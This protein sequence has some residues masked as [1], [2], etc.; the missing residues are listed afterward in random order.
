MHWL[1]C[2][3]HLCRSVW[4]TR[5]FASLSRWRF[6]TDRQVLEISVTSPDPTTI[7][8]SSSTAYLYKNINFNIILSPWIF[9]PWC[10]QTKMTTR[11]PVR[12]I[13][14]AQPVLQKKTKTSK[15][16]DVVKC[17]KTLILY[18]LRFGGWW[19]REKWQ[20]SWV[21]R[22]TKS[23]ETWRSGCCKKRGTGSL[24]GL[25]PW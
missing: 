3:I 6:A 25:G 19:E 7:V 11:S 21:H 22:G 13:C 5:Q 14:F 24:T 1:V 18:Q 15:R 17:P 23:G 10:F 4:E 20:R 2:K 12:S 16:Y 8:S 9:W